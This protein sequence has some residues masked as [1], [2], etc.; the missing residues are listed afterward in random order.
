MNKQ[1]Y[2]RLALERRDR[3]PEEERRDASRRIEER[4][5]ASHAMR[6]AENVL[7][8]C[9]YLS[10]VST[11]RLIE[12]MIRSGKK[13]FCPRIVDSGNGKMEFFRVRSSKDFGNGFHDIP[14]PL[15]QEQYI[16]GADRMHDDT[17][18]IIPGVAFDMKGN[19]IGYHGGYYDRYIPRVPGARLIAIAFDEQVFEDNFPM[20]A[21][22]IRPKALYTQTRV[23]ELQ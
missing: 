22:D 17:L 9:S 4:L 21:H 10:E 19:R 3:I 15:T 13:V 20:E 5:L 12:Q 18:M 8:Y 1:D 16:A 23:M 2:R 7:V 6:R 11:R 14:E